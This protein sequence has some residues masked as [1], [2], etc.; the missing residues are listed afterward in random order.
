VGEIVVHL[1]NGE[2][3][4]RVFPPYFFSPL[5]QWESRRSDS[6]D[7]REAMPS[8]FTI[9][10]PVPKK[11]KKGFSDVSAVVPPHLVL[12]PLHPY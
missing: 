5:G 8:S 11:Q 9:T 10:F 3:Y 7:Y 4:W 1:Q 12:F 6:V 2:R